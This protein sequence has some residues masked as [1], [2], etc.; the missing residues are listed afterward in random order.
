MVLGVGSG[1]D[2]KKEPP[3]DHFTSSPLS[4]YYQSWLAW[5]SSPSVVELYL[6]FIQKKLAYSDD[7]SEI[8]TILPMVETSV[9][10]GTASITAYQLY[11]NTRDVSSLAEYP[12][13]YLKKFL[14]LLQHSE[15]LDSSSLPNPERE[16]WIHAIKTV[17]NTFHSTPPIN[18]HKTAK[19]VSSSNLFPLIVF[20]LL[21]P[22]STD[23]S[24]TP[25]ENEAEGEKIETT[26]TRTLTCFYHS[27]SMYSIAL[28][29]LLRLLKVRQV[30]IDVMN[31]QY[32]RTLEHL[33]PL[34]ANNDL[35]MGLYHQLL[36]WRGE[37]FLS[38][39]QY[40]A[41][42]N[43]FSAVPCTAWIKSCLVW[44]WYKTGN[45]DQSFQSL[46][47][48]HVDEIPDHHLAIHHDR[49]GR[50]Y[51]H[52][53]SRNEELASM[54]FIKVIQ[55]TKCPK[56]LRRAFSLLGEL[57]RSRNLT[58]ALQCWQKALTYLPIHE[59][60]LEKYTR[61]CIEQGHFD[62]AYTILSETL[63]Q[64]PH[65]G[66][67]HKRLAF[68]HL[69]FKKYENSV[70]AFQ[71]AMRCLDHQHDATVY[72]GLAEAYMMLEKYG[73]ALKTMEDASK[74]SQTTLTFHMLAKAYLK[75]EKYEQSKQHLLKSG[76]D[77][78]PNV[79]LAGEV[80]LMYAR[81]CYK[82]G[83]YGACVELL[84][85][86]LDVLTKNDENIDLQAIDLRKADLLAMYM[87][88]PCLCDTFESTLEL[89]CSLYTKYQRNVPAAQVLLGL[90]S[91]TRIEN[92][93]KRALTLLQVANENEGLP[94]SEIWN[95]LGLV[96]ACL[97][98]PR[99][100]QHCFCTSFHAEDKDPWSWTS[101]GVLCLLNDDE[102]L[103][104]KS[105]RHALLCDPDHVY[106]WFGLALA[107]PDQCSIHLNHVFTIT[108]W[109]DPIGLRLYLQLASIP[110]WHGVMEQV[111]AASQY[112]AWDPVD[113]SAWHRLGCYYELAGNPEAACHAFKA[114]L[115][116]HRDSK[117]VSNLARVLL[118]IDP[119]QAH[120]LYER[121]QSM[122]VWHALSVPNPSTTF[123]DQCIASSSTW[124]N[125]AKTLLASVCYRAGYVEPI[126]DLL[127]DAPAALCAF[128]LVQ[129][130][131]DLIHQSFPM[132]L[133]F[134][135]AYFTSVYHLLKG[136]SIALALNALQ[137]SIHCDPSNSNGWIRLAQC[138]GRYAPACLD[139]LHL[140]F[141]DTYRMRTL[142]AL[143]VGK[144]HLALSCA[145]QHVRFYPEIESSWS[146]LQLCYSNQ[147]NYVWKSPYSHLL[148][149]HTS[150]VQGDVHNALEHVQNA[151]HQATHLPLGYLQYARVLRNQ[152]HF[153]EAIQ[154]YKQAWSE[155]LTF[156]ELVH[157]YITLGWRKA[158]LA[159]LAYPTHQIG[160]LVFHCLVDPISSGPSLEQLT[161]LS[162]S[163]FVQ[164]LAV[165]VWKAQ[166]F[167]HRSSKVLK[168]LKE[169][170]P[171]LAELIK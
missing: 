127:Q 93:V 23:I 89:A 30:E 111:V 63:T 45:V 50:M 55:T 123:L 16:E 82:V 166:G 72:H 20:C 135:T 24:E 98:Q 96:Y 64:F 139:S 4:T 75:T 156:L 124:E 56:L 76:W 36:G 168:I 129:G 47:E 11:F 2:T 29:N 14:S 91:H 83:R 40:D 134:E 74:F 73:A 152:G 157:T 43:D 143:A 92:Y 102:G 160:Q 116:L 169:T 41:A 120:S 7:L 42:I 119:A 52:E 140:P 22:L 37:A 49:V 77:F 106:A 163:I 8:K 5:D 107:E 114:S 80:Y 44:C 136:D 34:L 133:P 122:D 117:V 103:A 109:L 147:L 67:I 51:A 85:E 57:Y 110:S 138:L 78:A 90:F 145:Q 104:A 146:I 69:K 165:M 126:P 167:S 161:Q 137:K 15:T 86:G 1:L 87:Y 61:T 35:P 31:H 18:D 141:P 6:K 162:P 25:K 65:T 125:E 19:K 164:V 155:P 118:S 95:L 153:M 100:A 159:L 112:V 170:A 115:K 58:R 101:Y 53:T 130:Q 21:H 3:N 13:L 26:L 94:S 144:S 12:P 60:T 142:G 17:L 171:E 38:K 39:K 71:V 9:S 154:T 79:L 70:V 131:E 149:S 59:K 148:A 46:S 28:P 113:A 128:G 108:P 150:L 81:A 33:T 32:S 62:K 97:N 105:F 158:A 84:K 151:V 99:L 88:L 121:L 10:Q 54:A 66:W 132:L 68:L 48:L 27:T